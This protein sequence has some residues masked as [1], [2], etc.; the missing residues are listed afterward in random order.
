MT[1]FWAYPKSE[2]TLVS[3]DSSSQRASLLVGQRHPPSERALILHL[4][5]PRISVTLIATSLISHHFPDKMAI[6]RLSPADVT[7]VGFRV[8]DLRFPTSLNGVG[9]D[10]MHVGTNGSHPYIQ[11]ITNHPGL[12]GEGIVCPAPWT[13][14]QLR[15]TKNIH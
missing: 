14:V 6:P 5:S 11:L 1:I 10:A 7:I 13:R 4:P 2:L 9:S 3:T 12:I 8:I 15:C